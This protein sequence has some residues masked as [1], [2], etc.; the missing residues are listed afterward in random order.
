MRLFRSLSM[1]VWLLARDDHRPLCFTKN[2][3]VGSFDR[4]ASQM[5]GCDFHI[6][7]QTITTLV[8]QSLDGDGRT[9]KLRRGFSLLKR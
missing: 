1:G 6:D 2:P 5:L 3:L 9:A 7:Y 8:K 4:N